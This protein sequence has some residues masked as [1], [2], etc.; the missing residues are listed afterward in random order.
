MGAAASGPAIPSVSG[1][2][3]NP[4]LQSASSA[5]APLLSPEKAATD[6]KRNMA[7]A[8]APASG[9]PNP[10]ADADTTPPELDCEMFHR[11]EW[12][13]MS[14]LL[15]LDPDGAA[16]PRSPD[17]PLWRD[18]FREH[19]TI[20]NAGLQ[21][22]RALAAEAFASAHFAQRVAAAFRAALHAARPPPSAGPLGAP[23]RA[24]AL[25]FAAAMVASLRRADDAGARARIIGALGARQNVEI[26]AAALWQL[27]AVALDRLCAGAIPAEERSAACAVVLAFAA[28][29]PGP[30]GP[31]ALARIIERYA[32]PPAVVAGLLA[33]AARAAPRVSADFLLSL[34]PGLPGPAPRARLAAPAG[35]AAAAAKLA[36]TFT[37][38]A[39]AA[40]ALA[41]RAAVA[42][43]L[44]AEARAASDSL[45]TLL[46]LCS[47]GGP[48]GAYRA[49]LLGMRDAR[50]PGGTFQDVYE[51]LCSWAVH[52]AGARLAET[53]LVGNRKFRAYALARTDPDALVVPL[54]RAL[55]ARCAPPSPAADAYAPAA[56]LLSLTTDAGFC[57][58]VDQV[59][60]P[61]N[62]LAWPDGRGR[63][64]ATSVPVPMSSVILFVCSRAVQQALLAKRKRP[65][66]YTAGL[67]LAAMANVAASA[68]RVASPAA[69]R[70]VSLLDFLGR[71][72]R[73]LS[74]SAPLKTDEEA[75]SPPAPA[76]G[77][78]C[79][80]A[81]TAA[82]LAE[83]AG[84]ALEVIAGVLRSR[85]DVSGN[86]HLVYALLHREHLVARD[87]AIP[88]LSTRCAALC[89]RLEAVVRYFGKQVDRA[90]P[91]LSLAPGDA[92][93]V[94]SVE[95]VFAVIDETARLLPRDFLS[96]LPP[97]R[98]KLEPIAEESERFYE[99]VTWNIVRRFVP[100]AALPDEDVDPLVAVALCPT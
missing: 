97:L 73:R 41:P 10:P 56:A 87:S 33:A 95:R 59:L 3:A 35:L 47:A 38:R 26:G 75:E 13:A 62:N 2:V 12:P 91:D 68:T 93:A 90:Q 44:A 34:D 89:S 85:G 64:A 46:A 23:A 66:T 94:L 24:H 77:R 31:D 27:A 82:V 76:A 63:L 17:A 5:P 86:R 57:E 50:T 18:V 71:R 88:A 36:H 11:P 30:P 21:P 100:G 4:K 54:L 48:A 45:C 98:W 52:P 29:T 80:P 81:E 67:L 74:S 42:E 60:L 25:R 51:A 70:L 84:D 9:A 14:L 43:S 55:H 1:G 7:P 72:A 78:E 96:G 15:S 28:D 92:G 37:P 79:D 32:N 16:L 61:A 83:C 69:D 58:A 99:P 19:T 65:E 20:L 49:A 53:L 40:L 6:A 8:P 22:L 39:L